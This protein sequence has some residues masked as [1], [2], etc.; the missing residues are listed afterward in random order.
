MCE[1]HKIAA[2][3][4]R[5]SPP[6]SID[7]CLLLAFVLAVV[8]AAGVSAWALF[9]HPVNV[10][11]SHRESNVAVQVF[12]LG[13]VEARVTSK[14]GFKVSGVLVDLQ[15]DVGDRVPKGAM[16]ARLDDRE[17]SAR[18]GR[19]RASIEQAE[20]NLQRAT[21]GVGK[22]QA[23]YANAK[24][25]NERRQKLV[26]SNITSTETAQTAKQLRMPRWPM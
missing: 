23:N 25:I 22:A 26:Q 2:P 11:V 3:S 19:A 12:G 13:T 10:K 17:Q 8:A 20:A 21:A 14:V 5:G 18:V 4:M 6:G 1:A 16:L 7:N 9:L 24:S 15:A